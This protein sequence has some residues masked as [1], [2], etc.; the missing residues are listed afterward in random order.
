M[1][2]RVG[3]ETNDVDGGVKGKEGDQHPET[4]P[5]KDY[6]GVKEAWGKSKEKV[7]SLEEQLK[8]T[9]NPEELTKVKA[10]LETT[11]TELQKTT[12]ELK[13]TTE[14]T[15]TEKRAALVKKGVPEEKVKEMSA[16]E[17]DIVDSVIGIKPLAD[18]GGGG[19][20]GTVATGSPMEMARQAYSK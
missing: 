14:K 2:D 6:V 16:K 1:G 19:G 18:L 13:T 12:D 8:K 9:T 20:G 10:E 11:K 3:E 4:I 17:L 15:L 5:W 7:V